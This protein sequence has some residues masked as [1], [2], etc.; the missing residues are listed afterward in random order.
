[1]QINADINL[2]RLFYCILYAAAQV[3]GRAA[4]CTERKAIHK[5]ELKYDSSWV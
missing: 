3:H 1:M 2:I 4:T 5:Y